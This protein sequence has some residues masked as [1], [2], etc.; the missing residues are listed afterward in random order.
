MRRQPALILRR[1]EILGRTPLVRL[2]KVIRA[3]SAQPPENRDSLSPRFQIFLPF[4][5]RF[6][7]NSKVTILYQNP[8][9][10]VYRQS[11]GLLSEERV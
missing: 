6:S 8:D 11:R 2:P 1:S 4:F 5:D 10:T 7:A 9:K 3:K